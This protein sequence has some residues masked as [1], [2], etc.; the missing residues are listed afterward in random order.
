MLNRVRYKFISTHLY[1][2]MKIMGFTLSK[3]KGLSYHSGQKMLKINKKL[4]FREFL[5]IVKNTLAFIRFNV[6]NNTHFRRMFQK[7]S[8]RVTL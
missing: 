5:K 8:I 1:W 4:I 2:L 6:I 3:E 7:S